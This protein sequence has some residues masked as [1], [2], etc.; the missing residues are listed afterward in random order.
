MILCYTIINNFNLASKIKRRGGESD[1]LDT[2]IQNKS[3]HRPRRTLFFSNCLHYAIILLTQ[4][5]KFM[6]KNKIKN[7]F[8]SVS[9]A[10]LFAL[11]FIMPPL[12]SKKA[13]AQSAT[14]ADTLYYYSDYNQ[15]PAYCQSFVSMGLINDYDFYYGQRAEL[16]TRLLLDY[17]AGVISPN[18]YIVLELRNGLPSDNGAFI[19]SLYNLFGNLK[20]HGCKIMFIDGTNEI[21]YVGHDDFLDY[22]DIHIN[23]DVFFALVSNMFLRAYQACGDNMQLENISFILDKSLT[24]NIESLGY[25]QSW[26]FNNY[27]D[28][29]FKSVYESELLSGG[30][31]RTQLLQSHGIQTLCHTPDDT[32]ADRFYALEA[33]AFTDLNTFLSDNS[34]PVFSMGA[35]YLGQT[36][37]LDWIRLMTA[38]R[39]AASR[40]FPIYIH[41]EANYAFGEYSAPDVYPLTQPDLFDVMADF[42]ADEDMTVYDNVEGRCIVTYC[43]LCANNGWLADAHYGEG[44]FY[45]KYLN[46]YLTQEEQEN[47]A[48]IDS[49]W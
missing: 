20:E 11:M 30:V 37:S 32:S 24:E 39:T 31:S 25:K 16:F 28:V 47:L 40:D 27:F 2:L 9:M 17:N 23:V 4:R 21:R 1:A 8:I 10:F 18:S 43:P 48:I 5:E 13:S 14:A 19:S 38:G 33:N 7:L 15:S 36:Y 34:N 45:V 42:L 6:I 22:V 12:G 26:F 41:N 35:T 3:P 44:D 46:L 49:F 29:Y